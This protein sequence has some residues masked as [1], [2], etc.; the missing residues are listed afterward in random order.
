MTLTSKNYLH[1]ATET[2]Q[3]E[4]VDGTSSEPL[5]MLPQKSLKAFLGTAHAALKATPSQRSVPLH[6]VVGNESADLDSLCSTLFLAYFRSHTPPHVLHVPLCHLPRGDIVL[7]PEFRAVML[8]AGI[9]RKDLITLSELPMGVGEGEGVLKAEDTKWLLVDHNALTG[10]LGKEYG[11]RV[12]GCIDH[13]DD[14]G[15]IPKDAELRVIEKTGS[16]MSLIVEQCRETWDALAK[17]DE[18]ADAEA[19]AKKVEI[20]RQ[21]AYLALAPILVDTAN[22]GNKDKTTAHDE[23]AVEIAEGYLLPSSTAAAATESATDVYD[24]SGF[25]A[26]ISALKEDISHLSVHDILRKD[27]KEWTEGALKLGTTS[28]PQSF[29][30]ILKEVGKMSTLHSALAR[31]MSGNGLDVMVVL[32][33]S[34]NDKGEFARELLLWARSSPHVTNAVR[35]FMEGEATEKL[36]LEIPAVPW[37]PDTTK[38]C[39]RMAWNQ[40]NVEFSRKQIAPMLR[41]VLKKL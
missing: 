25:Y 13:H 14:E 36:G 16:C 24:R 39:W 33:T 21:L 1:D 7:R 20:N 3:S 38:G 18:N 17:G 22:L 23:R 37:E 31:I 12:V 30:V 9:K 6:F 35:E 34:K 28:V 11:N 29:D 4:V 15:V 2:T 32:T 40:K 19:V 5:K 41:D 8:R 27:Y 10:K 26:K